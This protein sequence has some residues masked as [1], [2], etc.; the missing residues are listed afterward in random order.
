MT[1]AVENRQLQ[2]S[3]EESAPGVV[4]RSREAVAAYLRR[5]SYRLAHAEEELAEVVEQVLRWPSGITCA[6]GEDVV[7]WHWLVGSRRVHLHFYRSYDVNYLPYPVEDHL[8]GARACSCRACRWAVVAMCDEL[9]ERRRRRLAP[10]GRY[11]QYLQERL[12]GVAEV[13]AAS[14]SACVLESSDR[15]C[16]V[17]FTPEAGS[18]LEVVLRASGP[19][20]FL[21]DDESLFEWWGE[22][23]DS[24]WPVE[25]VEVQSDGGSDVLPRDEEVLTNFLFDI[26]GDGARPPLVRPERGGIS[27]RYAQGQAAFMLSQPYGIS[28]VTGKYITPCVEAE[29]TWHWLVGSRKIHVQV[30]ALWG[31]S[32]VHATMGSDWLMAD[33]PRCRCE[34]RR[35]NACWGFVIRDCDA[36][37]H[38]LERL[39]RRTNVNE[40][41]LEEAVY[42]GGRPL[43]VRE[44]GVLFRRLT[45][46]Y[47][48]YD[49]L[50]MG[51]V[52]DELVIVRWTREREAAARAAFDQGPE[53]AR[54]W[55]A[56]C[57]LLLLDPEENDLAIGDPYE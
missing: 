13:V 35:C 43:K 56:A 54:D 22:L 12:A 5:S 37:G 31:I 41:L 20:K 16:L 26:L 18:G 8:N 9:R 29:I 57:Q 1:D 42:L 14:P 46:R 4:P 19:S 36:A 33:S 49:P 45:S 23:L 7:Q 11:V 30:S 17:P 48:R 39:Q 51:I 27:Y 44:W 28:F 2:G 15:V 47:S 40:G 10:Q 52:D 38:I 25:M 24:R 34:E 55:R 6:A 3:D 32:P 21:D 50:L 53:A